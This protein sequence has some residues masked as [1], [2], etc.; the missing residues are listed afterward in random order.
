MGRLRVGMSA[1]FRERP[2]SD[3]DDQLIAAYECSGTLN[4]AIN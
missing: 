2:M 3:L 4:L 1:S